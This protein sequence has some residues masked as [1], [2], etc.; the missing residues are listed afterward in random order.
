[1]HKNKAQVITYVCL[2]WLKCK[3]RTNS[4][5]IFASDA[6]PEEESQTVEPFARADILYN[7]NVDKIAAKFE[8]SDDAEPGIK[9]LSCKKT[10]FNIGRL[11]HPTYNKGMDR[12]DA[13]FYLP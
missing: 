5:S 7:R 11:L 10:I 8:T 3:S 6:T 12:I 2:I 4:R 13:F 1:M 9:K